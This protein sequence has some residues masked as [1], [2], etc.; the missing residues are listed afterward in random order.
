MGSELFRKVLEDAGIRFH[1]VSSKSDHGRPRYD[2]N[3]KLFQQ[4]TL[5]QEVLNI[6]EVL[7]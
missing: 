7:V 4:K 2:H 3:N 5:T 6:R 1:L